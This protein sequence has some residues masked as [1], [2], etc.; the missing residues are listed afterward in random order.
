LEHLQALYQHKLNEALSEAFE[1]ELLDAAFVNLLYP[2]KLRMNNFGYALRGL[3]GHMLHRL[4]P[5]D[6]VID[7]SWFKS[8]SGTNEITPRHQ[9]KFAIQGGLSD[10][11]VTKVLKVGK[12]NRIASELV[13]IINEL[14]SYTHIKQST[15]N[16]DAELTEKKAKQCLKVT[17]KFVKKIN[18][19]RNKVKNK[20]IKVIDNKLIETACFEPVPELDL[21]STHHSVEDVSLQRI[22]G[23]S[24]GAHSIKMAVEASVYVKQWYGSNFDCRKGDGFEKT[25]T[26]PACFEIEVVFEKPLGSVISVHDYTVDTSKDDLLFL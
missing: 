4:A 23:Q 25:A 17:L 6:E 18:E 15:F 8:R 14:D 10:K 24:I 7:C 26:F 3:I 2:N 11:F 16:I 22:Y 20:L 19:I 5:N 13:T 1:R 12:I 9:I 21:L